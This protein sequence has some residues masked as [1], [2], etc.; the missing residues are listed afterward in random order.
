MSVYFILEVLHFHISIDSIANKPV[1]V[2]PP[3]D[4]RAHSTKKNVVGPVVGGVIGGLALITA[5]TLGAFLWRRRSRNY[6]PTKAG[7]QKSGIDP[8]AVPYDYN[9]SAGTGI[10]QNPHGGTQTPRSSSSLPVAFIQSGVI[11]STKARE[12]ARN[13][14]RQTPP[15]TL[16]SVPSTSTALATSRE[17]PTDPEPS[18]PIGAA[19]R[20]SSLDVVGLRIEVENLRRA[21]QD[22]QIDR[23]EAPPGYQDVQ[24]QTS[25]F[26]NSR[27][28]ASEDSRPHT[29]FP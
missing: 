9:P 27:V 22:I 20:M 13:R 18:T 23:L 6:L 11:L 12:A 3:P 2:P 14:T 7:I 29:P 15:D 4:P 19:P 8:E 1:L 24:A 16:I 26:T 5:I 10:Y 25:N 28:A 17:P 21:M